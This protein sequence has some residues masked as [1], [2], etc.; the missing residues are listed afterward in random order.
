MLTLNAIREISFEEFQALNCS[1]YSRTVYE[2]G[3]EILFVSKKGA[4]IVQ[5]I[6]PDRTIYTL[7]SFSLRDAI[8]S[9]MDELTAE[10]AELKRK[11][12]TTKPDQ[13]ASE[14][15]LTDEMAMDIT[16][17]K[18][19]NTQLKER[20]AFLEGLI[21]RHLPD[22]CKAPLHRGEWLPIMEAPRDGSLILGYDPDMLGVCTAY[23]DQDGWYAVSESQDGMGFSNIMLTK[24]LVIPG[25]TGIKKGRM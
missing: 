12:M 14:T 17:F 20:V 15:P 23:W 19:E 21:M 1:E 13:P 22:T 8:L 5:E 2:H 4:Y 10:N 3:E 25:F 6:R 24:Y 11:N 9:R 7:I 18:G 16:R